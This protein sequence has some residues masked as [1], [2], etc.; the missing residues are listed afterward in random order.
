M[1]MDAE[2]AAVAVDVA[3]DGDAAVAAQGWV[4]E[5]ST[6][7]GRQV[8]ETADGTANEMMNRLGRSCFDQENVLEKSREFQVGLKSLK[9]ENP[10]AGFGA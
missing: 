4:E 7:K 1:R 9:L 5:K 8:E 10:D 2:V 6:E 3:V